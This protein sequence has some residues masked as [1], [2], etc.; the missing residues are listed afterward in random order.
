[1]KWI[2]L[3]FFTLIVW[4]GIYLYTYLGFSEKVE[5]SISQSSPMALIYVRHLGA[6]HKINES[7]TK[8]EQSLEKKGL[9]C[10]KTFGEFLDNP[11]EVNEDRLTSHVGCLFLVSEDSP[12]AEKGGRLE[13]LAK[14]LGFEYE[15]RLSQPVIKASF[16]GSPSIGPFKVYP[17]IDEMI[18]D[19][20]RARSGPLMEIYEIKGDKVLTTYFQ[21]IK[22]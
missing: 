2:F 3:S 13:S 15:S 18:Q 4:V 21:P 12:A 7:L 10:S 6:Y 17:K 22:D 1:L 19:L 11:D 8:I 5:V 20:R 9:Q 16:R 14:E